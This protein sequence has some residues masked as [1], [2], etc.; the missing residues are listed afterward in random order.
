M[1]FYTLT[2]LGYYEG[3][4]HWEPTLDP[5]VVEMRIYQV[6]HS[7][8]N[9]AGYASF[10]SSA[11]SGTFII[12]NGCKSIHGIAYT[13]TGKS[14]DA[15]NSLEIPCLCGDCGSPPYSIGFENPVPPS[16]DGRITS[17]SSQAISFLAEKG[18]Y[19]HVECCNS[20]TEGNWKT[21]TIIE[22]SFN[23]D[24]NYAIDTSAHDTCFY[25]VT[26]LN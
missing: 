19:Y 7:G 17:L 11:L 16:Q 4:V 12:L 8:E 25:R 14:S 1:S 18:T 10:P 5:S 22:P 20:L 21:L 26:P 13:S 3:T 23:G 24:L 9:I 15:S 6:A 2:T